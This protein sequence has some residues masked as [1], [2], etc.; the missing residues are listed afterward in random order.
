MNIELIG[1]VAK[2][3][4]KEIS[5]LQLHK[6]FRIAEFDLVLLF[7]NTRSHMVLISADPSIPRAYLVRRKLRE[8]RRQALN[9]S[10]LEIEF[11]KA[12]ESRP[13]TSVVAIPNDRIIEIA[14][15]D[16]TLVIQ[17]TGRSANVFLLDAER[18][19]VSSLRRFE[20]EGQRYGDVYKLPQT[21]PR[22]FD[23]RL[24]PVDPPASVSAAL[25]TH[26]SA[27]LE[28]REFDSIAKRA[29]EEA[30]REKVKLEKLLVNLERDLAGHGDAEHWKRLGDLLLAN[31]ATAKR[32]GDKIVVTDYFD[33][34]QPP[35]EIEVE[36]TDSVTEAAEKYFARY[37]K[38][39][40]ASVEIKKRIVEVRQRMREAG[41]RIAAVEAAI[42]EREI[43]KLRSFIDEERPELRKL[44]SKTQKLPGVRKFISSEG[45]E[46]L[47]GKKATDND[48]LTF[49]VAASRDTWMHAADYPGS[50]VVIR[51]PKRKAI[52]Q[53]TLIEAAQLAAFYSQGNKQT[54]AA[55]HYTERKFV[56]KIKGAAPGLVRLASFKT[57][58]VEPKFPTV[59]KE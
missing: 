43:G 53:P 57:L 33:P 52:P 4:E 59:Q 30:K 26:Y 28:T 47:V 21:A 36:A 54:K 8:I 16:N 6:V 58:L 5:G 1:Q 55:V 51:N 48:R 27:L 34:Q 9:A 22:P 37:A 19:I 15:A 44:R 13:I 10:R 45:F 42:V 56:N 11:T 12:F 20:A 50:H 24:Q 23:D 3:L 14:T 25:D 46:I 7:E 40:N 39:R 41:N 38:A 35:L 49:R 31:V 17:L 32:Q 18:R 29:R 2:E